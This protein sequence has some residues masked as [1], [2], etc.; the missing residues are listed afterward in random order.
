MF[1][2]LMLF[3]G[4]TYNFFGRN[5]NSLRC[6]LSNELVHQPNVR[7]RSSAHDVIIP[8]T[9]TVRI[10]ITWFET[11]NSKNNINFTAFTLIC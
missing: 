5:M 8:A 2:K 11:V 3:R 10:E 6:G 1:V 7:E 9:R 4:N